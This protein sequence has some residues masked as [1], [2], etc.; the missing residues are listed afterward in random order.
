MVNLVG[1]MAAEMNFQ[2]SENTSLSL[3]ARVS[4]L[5]SQKDDGGVNGENKCIRNVIKNP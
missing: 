5:Q 2:T 4:P 1:M 3:S